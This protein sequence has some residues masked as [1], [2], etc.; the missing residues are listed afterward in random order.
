MPSIPS[1]AK[2]SRREL[3]KA[4]GVS[5]M[6]T[7]KALL[8]QGADPTERDPDGSTA[9]HYMASRQPFDETAA[10]LIE[11]G[12]DLNAKNLMGYTPLMKAVFRSNVPAIR[13]LV[14]HGTVIDLKDHTNRSALDYAIK[15]ASAEV[16]ALLKD[17]LAQ[18]ARPKK[19]IKQELIEAIWARDMDRLKTLLEQGADPNTVDESYYNSTP[20][21]HSISFSDIEI[22]KLFLDYKADINRRSAQDYT[23]LMLAASNDNLP[24]V[25]LFLDHGAN[26]NLKNADGNTAFMIAAK[27]NP[28]IA[29]LLVEHG[30]DLTI[31]DDT[32]VCDGVR[33]LIKE[34]EIAGFHKLALENQA[35][36][37]IRSIKFKSRAGARP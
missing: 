32:K 21:L 30:A 2:P 7:A 17:A 8:E 3:L 28:A 37:K 15:T 14:A 9:L 36:L 11:H 23:P 1:P 33:A 4:V 35:S 27:H 19:T 25:K 29:R 24:L 31:N 16:V 26:P 13:F 5:D 18:P 10:L 6:K 34:V 22:A 20:L 12:A